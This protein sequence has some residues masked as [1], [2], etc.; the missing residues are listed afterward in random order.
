MA[1]GSLARSR[2]TTPTSEGSAR[3]E[4]G[5]GSENKVSLIAAVQTTED[6][7]AELACLS[8]MPFCNQA[9]AEFAAHSLVRPLTV[10]SDGLACFLATEKAGVHQRV[11]TG[12]GKAGQAA[13]V[14]GDQH[15]A[16]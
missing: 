14:E 8:L 7:Q 16:E 9:I 4:T 13:P 6:G 3:T 1:V 12:G 15:G 11:V 10:V 5:R 2:S